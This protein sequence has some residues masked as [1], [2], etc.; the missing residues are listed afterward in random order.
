MRIEKVA[1]PKTYSFKKLLTNQRPV[2]FIK[3]SE[4]TIFEIFGK[5]E[6]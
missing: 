2:E 5:V 4:G 1:F 3:T 6:K